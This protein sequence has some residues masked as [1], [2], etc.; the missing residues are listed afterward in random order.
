MVTGL[1]LSLLKSPARRIL[2]RHLENTA[3]TE[4]SCRLKKI[5][6]ADFSTICYWG[7]PEPRLPALSPAGRFF[8]YAADL[9][10]SV[11]KM[12]KLLHQICTKPVEIPAG[13][14]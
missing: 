1:K 3:I 12:R 2:S 5:A 4:C 9:C 7:S 6:A 10:K 13:P 14:S 8:F 11:A